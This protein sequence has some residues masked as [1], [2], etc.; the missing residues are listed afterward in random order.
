MPSILRKRFV[1]PF[2]R[3]FT[4]D[5]THKL[6]HSQGFW[7]SLNSATALAMDNFVEKSMENSRIG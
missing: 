4:T 3:E 5:F 1:T 6:S 2:M 7:H